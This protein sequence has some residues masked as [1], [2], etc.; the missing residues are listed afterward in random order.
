LV[1]IPRAGRRHCAR[2]R[3]PGAGSIQI[4][5]AV[6][7]ARPHRRPISFWVIFDQPRHETPRS[8]PAQSVFPTRS[9]ACIKPSAQML[10]KSE[11]NSNGRTR[12]T[13]LQRLFGTSSSPLPGTRYP[14]FRGYQGA[15]SLSSILPISCFC[16]IFLLFGWRSRRT[17]MFTSASRH[18]GD[19][20][21]SRAGFPA[22][23]VTDR[24][25]AVKLTRYCAKRRT[26]RFPAPGARHRHRGTGNRRPLLPRALAPGGTGRQRIGKPPW[27]RSHRPHRLVRRIAGT[28]VTTSEKGALS[29][30]A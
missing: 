16:R 20:A 8:P 25:P 26:H 18:V 1:R 14:F 13:C 15:T 11:C 30:I 6:K 9:G 23:R 21:F 5:H 29:V 24:G 3:N 22:R 7:A 4:A 10:G 19:S 2:G 12:S 17:T 28:E 27:V